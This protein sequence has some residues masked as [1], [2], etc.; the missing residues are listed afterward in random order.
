[1]ASQAVEAEPPL[2]EEVAMLQLKQY[3]ELQAVKLSHEEDMASLRA[4]VVKASRK[5]H[6]VVQ[7]AC[8]QIR[9]KRALANAAASDR[10]A[11][12]LE[13]KTEQTLLHAAAAIVEAPSLPVF[14]GGPG[15]PGPSD[16]A[17]GD[18]ARAAAHAA[19]ATA[20]LETRASAV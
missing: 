18:T 2:L 3:N 19:Q 14:L 1:M 13:G 12:D 16:E 10:F 9:K 5:T 8:V 17:R 6:Y 7:W 20:A 4:E 15:G 11:D